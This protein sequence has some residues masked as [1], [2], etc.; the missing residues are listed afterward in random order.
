MSRFSGSG[1][2]AQLSMALSSAVPTMVQISR[3]VRNPSARPSATLVIRMFFSWQSMLLA[4]NKVSSTGLPV[5]FSASYC[6]MPDS[7][8]A[9]AASCLARSRSARM[10]AIC[11]F[12]S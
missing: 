2:A 9:S 12:S 11:T 6:K 7:I 10:S 5:L 1:S 8:R 4:V 3:V